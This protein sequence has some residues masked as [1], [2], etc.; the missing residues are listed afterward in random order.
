MWLS[1]WKDLWRADRNPDTKVR[2]VDVQVLYKVNQQWE[3]MSFE[4]LGYSQGYSLGYNLAKMPMFKLRE[5]QATFK[6]IP[7]LI[8][9]VEFHTLEAS[10]QS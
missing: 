9:W 4:L 1:H 6:P 3:P 7:F 8:T 2:N 5:Q 10:A